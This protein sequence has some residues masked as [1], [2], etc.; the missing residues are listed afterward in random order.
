LVA[1]LTEEH[2]RVTRISFIGYSAGGLFSRYCVGL[3]QLNGFFD[4]ITP[5]SFVTLACPHLGV[6]RGSPSAFSRVFNS[7]AGWAVYR[8]GAQLTLADRHGPAAECLLLAMSRPSSVFVSGLQRFP[9]LV[10]FANAVAD[11]TVPYHTASLR[12]RNVYSLATEGF[13]LRSRFSQFP[14]VIASADALKLMQLHKS[15]LQP[16]ACDGTEGQVV[17]REAEST[18]SWL[19]VAARVGIM[20]ALLP[21]WLV[22]APTVTA[23]II[24]SKNSANVGQ[25]QYPV[26][27]GDCG[28]A[29]SDAHVAQGAATTFG[30][31][32][33]EQGLHTASHAEQGLHTASHAE[34][35]L[36]TA[37]TS[38]CDM[39]S[40]ILQGIGELPWLRVDV[41]LPGP[42]THGR[43]V[44]RRPWIDGSGQDVVKFLVE[45]ALLR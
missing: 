10:L 16:A 37:S 20:A 21:V 17:L 45:V 44:V 43:I 5:V 41:C 38:T 39:K 9:R 24:R 42:H 40:E 15:S 3:M 36:H 8:S 13:D 34:Q 32:H 19:E 30:V 28:A 22:A 31:S 23:L 11:R 29:T 4:R 35:G 18:G 27:A 33:A 1:S 25:L 26:P 6:R 12:R 14:H 7:V 2:A